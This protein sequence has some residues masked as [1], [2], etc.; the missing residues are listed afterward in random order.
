MN[1]KSIDFSGHNFEEIGR[2]LLDNSPNRDGREIRLELTESEQAAFACIVGMHIGGVLRSL[3][4]DASAAAGNRIEL[5]FVYDV[6][7]RTFTTS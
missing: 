5:A 6:M 2:I 4:E 3:I 7:T 1:G